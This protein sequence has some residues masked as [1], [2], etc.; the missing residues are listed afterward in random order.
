MQQLVV[1]TST[2][3]S[4]AP[5]HRSIQTVVA[6]SGHRQPVPLS[7]RTP[8]RVV[9]KPGPTDGADT[10]SSSSRPSCGRSRHPRLPGTP[11]AGFP[12]TMDSCTSMDLQL[13]NDPSS[14]PRSF[15]RAVHPIS[16]AKFPNPLAISLPRRAVKQDADL[17]VAER[18]ALPTKSI[19]LTERV[20]TFP[21]P[22]TPER[23]RDGGA[24]AQ[25]VGQIPGRACR[26]TRA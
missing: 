17:A 18:Q 20:P 23:P 11:P 6:P 21:A 25:V 26:R 7:A 16:M 14:T 12:V 4:T 8:T 9:L 13:W 15:G 5:A 2:A 22:R 10:W 1:D 19:E 3:R 24:D